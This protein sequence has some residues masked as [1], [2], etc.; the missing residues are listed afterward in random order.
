MTCSV[1]TASAIGAT[2]DNRMVANSTR[3]F[4]AALLITLVVK[5]ALAAIIPVTADEAYYIGW[6]NRLALGYYEHPPM[7]GWM[8]YFL[9]RIGHGI[10][11]M[12]L[13]AVLWSTLVAIGIHALLKRRDRD[14]GALAA[15]LFVVSPISVVGV[16]ITTD[17]PLIL[18]SYASAA[19]LFLAL[20][21]NRRFYYLLSGVFL[22][23]AFLSKYFAALLGLSYLV[24]FAISRRWRE[25]APGFL[26][27][28]AASLPFVSLNIYWNYTHC[29]DNVL[30]NLVTRNRDAAL[31]AEKFLTYLG[32]A[33]YLITP[34]I[35][36]YLIKRRDQLVRQ[37]SGDR[38]GIFAIAWL[39]PLAIFAVLATVKDIGLHWPLSFYPFLFLSIYTILSD[40]EYRKAI[41]F[42]A[43]F[44]AL[45]VAA[46]AALVY[47]PR[48]YLKHWNHY[49]SI[50]LVEQNRRLQEDLK[51]YWDKYYLA[52]NQYSTSSLMTYLSG[53]DFFVFGPASYHSRQDDID[54]DFR[55]FDGRDI[56]ILRKTAPE[57]G[58]YSPFFKSV[59]LKEIVVEQ[60]PF[61]IVLGHQFVYEAYRN[62]VLRFIKSAYYNIP[63]YLPHA[64][65]YMDQR[66]GGSE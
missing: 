61:Y 7:I 4:Y 45:H 40:W 31:S 10:L 26:V 41:C 29:W 44:A 35:L 39:I 55:R 57:K 56:L 28:L 48:D 13:P 6:G 54:T 62:R 34:P 63:R 60:A 36:V 16:F 51:P 2:S 64:A 11:L 32:C 65:C 8:L 14:K 38:L 37:V 59:Q 20:E 12:R 3:L 33:A 52:T 53:R 46:L 49:D 15:T 1:A 23:L 27:L 21:G 66:Y 18:F 30:F 24:Y 50:V 5:L 25:L 47:L 17:I 19:C 43:V 22:G 42:M 9:R 58:E